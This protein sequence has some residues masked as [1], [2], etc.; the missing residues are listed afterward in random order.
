MIGALEMNVRGGKVQGISHGISIFA[1]K[2]LS[3]YKGLPVTPI[4]R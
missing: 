3:G 4:H 1:L 2:L